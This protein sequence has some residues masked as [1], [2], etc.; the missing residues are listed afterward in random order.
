MAS[1]LSKFFEEIDWDA[2]DKPLP[3]EGHFAAAHLA[4]LFR[5]KIARS[6]ATGKDGTRIGR[7][8]EKLGDETQLIERKVLS[9]TYNFTTFKERLIL[10]G[11]YR[12]PRQISI[13]TVRDRLTLR[14][15]CQVLHTYVP[16]SVGPSPHSLVREV[17]TAIKE[18]YQRHSFVRIDV[19]NFFPT[20]LHHRLENELGHH[21]IDAKIR[22]LCLNAIKTPTGEKSHPNER[23]V[24]QGLSISGALASTFMLRFDLL[25]RKRIRH[26]FRYVDDILIICPTSQAKS[27]LNFVSSSLSRR[28]LKAHALGTEGKTEIRQV[29]EGI[30]FLGYHISI[31][32]VSV[33]ESSFR[34]MFKNLLK[35]ITD[36]RY[37]R[38]ADR[39]L[40]RL[41]LKISGCQVDS[42]RR[43]WMMYFSQ[44]EDLNQLQFLDRFVKQQLMR[45][46]FPADR[47]AQTKTF[48]KSYHEIKYN[49]AASS[50]IPN[51][52]VFTHDE[53]VAAIAS[54]TDHTS[55]EVIA[56]SI[57]NI[58]AEF[59]RLISKE[60]QG[61]ERDVGSP[62]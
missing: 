25:H 23:G 2:L 48:I 46:G 18:D 57:E 60:I 10:R 61:L 19:K 37:R 14:A 38:D 3:P 45:V 50:Y 32:K 39:T 59:N 55:A 12:E 9:D 42:K 36:Y 53:K 56:W 34:R 4:E 41:N 31:G 44:T 58:E 16:K 52:D 17:V 35:V 15:L 24:P 33:R 62:S 13:P 28:G 6:Q 11:A 49:L 5:L 7:F 20:I 51:F 47:I 43:G 30:D 27:E 21:G 1:D 26:F 54:L 8:S 22:Q 40:F 29:S